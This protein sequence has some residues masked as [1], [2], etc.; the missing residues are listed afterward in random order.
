MKKE[1]EFGSVA[2]YFTPAPPAGPAQP[3]QPVQPPPTNSTNNQ[4]YLGLNHADNGEF[5]KIF[6]IK[7]NKYKKNF[8]RANEIWN[9]RDSKS[10]NRSAVQAEAKLFSSW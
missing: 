7:F 2:N 5:L 6:I 4:E 9:G 10:K 8:A 1:N 3:T